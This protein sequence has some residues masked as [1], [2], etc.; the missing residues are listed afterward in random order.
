MGSSNSGTA[1]AQTEPYSTSAPAAEAA[2]PRQGRRRGRGLFARLIDAFGP[3]QEQPGDDTPAPGAHGVANLLNLRVDDVSVPK[4]EIVAVPEDISRDELVEVFRQSGFS[5]LPVYK[6]TLDHPQGQLLLKDLALTHGFGASTGRFSLTGL[7]RPVLYVPPS[8]QVGVLLQKMQ[9]E[10]VHLALV[11]DEYGGVDGL[12]TI[13]DLIETVLGDIEDEHDE[14]ETALW[15]EEAPGVYLAQAVAPL[16]E[17]EAATG[18]RLRI[19]EEDEEIDTLGGLIFLRTGRVP[20]PGEVVAHESGAVLE[21]LDA[22]A[23]RVKRLRVRMPG[24]VAQGA[25]V[26][27]DSAAQ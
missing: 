13:E 1:P 2:P 9:R 20:A 23:R 19:G 4:A 10:R 5:R 15:K 12:V 24:A 27:E 3:D 8:M 17:F 7:I 11:I 26:T 6:G 21:V 22:D 14:E 18:L 25:P 16:D